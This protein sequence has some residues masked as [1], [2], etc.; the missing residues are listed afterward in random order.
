MTQ[1]QISP[2]VK[3]RLPRYY[4]YLSELL[5]NER[6]KISSGE[7]SKLMAVTASQIRQ[8]LNCF[9]GFGQQ[10]YGYNIEQLH[11]E[12]GRI[13][14]VKRGFSAVI[15]GTGS[16]GATLAKSGIFSKRG[17]CLLALFDNDPEVIGKKIA[18]FTVADIRY[19]AAYCREHK[20]DIAALTLPKEEAKP[21]ADM[22]AAAGVRGF[23]NFSNM[24]LK[25]DSPGVKVENIHM[26]DS[27]MMLC[28]QLNN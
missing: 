25:I 9:G 14:G 23:W 8:D 27:L 12:I 10:G 2:A 4:R 5:K 6:Y 18:G 24:E 16:L 11:E 3:N 7:L 26:G 20:I 17:I 28:L 22:F 21:V 19:A 15:A 1:K 13:L